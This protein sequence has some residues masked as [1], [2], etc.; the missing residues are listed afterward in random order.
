MS[1]RYDLQR[2]LEKYADNVYFQPPSSIKM[3][4]PCVVY[5]KISKFR[6]YG[7]DQAYIKIQGYSVTVMDRDPDSLI[8]DDLE[9]HFTHCAI[10]QY[11]T[12]DNIHHTVLELYY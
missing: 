7:N 3:T 8:A 4:Y 5:N 1:K 9:D 12:N 6:E 10:T 2:E 11:F